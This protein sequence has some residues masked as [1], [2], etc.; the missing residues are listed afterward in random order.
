M[1]VLSRKCDEKVMLRIDEIEGV[2]LPYP[3]EI[4]LTV[5]KIE[6]KKVRI[7]IQAGDEVFVVRSEL[8]EDAHARIA[9]KVAG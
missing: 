7:G 8:T 9:A 2:E 6:K 4:E 5:V 1:L 3:I